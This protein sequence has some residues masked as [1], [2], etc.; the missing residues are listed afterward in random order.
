MSKFDANFSNIFGILGQKPGGGG[1]GGGGL[2][3]K[4]KNHK[5]AH[6]VF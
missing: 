6:F 4:G 2:T 5:S 3:P 1:G